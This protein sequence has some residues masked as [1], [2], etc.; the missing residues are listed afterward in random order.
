MPDNAGKKYAPGWQPNSPGESSTPGWSGGANFMG[1]PWPNAVPTLNALANDP[2]TAR[3]R[4]ILP[5]VNR[6]AFQPENDLFISGF[7]GKS[8]G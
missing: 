3:R 5:D 4:A 7:V 2:G 6:Y 1:V 8:Q